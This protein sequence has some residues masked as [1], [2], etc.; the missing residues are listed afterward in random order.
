ME[1]KLPRLDDLVRNLPPPPKEE[2][3][4]PEPGVLH[5]VYIKRRG[6]SDLLHILSLYEGKT[7]V[8]PAPLNEF[9]VYLTVKL[10]PGQSKPFLDAL[11]E[12]GIRYIAG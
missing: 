1:S 7:I 5:I 4:E 8:P 11:Y 6:L 12:D 10:P 9:E 2:T 3:G